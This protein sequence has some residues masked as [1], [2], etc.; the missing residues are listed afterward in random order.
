MSEQLIDLERRGDVWVLHLC[1]EDNRFNRA[2][3]D[4]LHRALDQVESTSGPA[5][6]VTTGAGKFYSNGL[7]LDWLLGGGPDTE[8]FLPDV[9]RLLGRVLGLDVVTVAAINGHAFA[10]GAMLASAHDYRIMRE[11]RGYWCLPEVDLGLPLTP[12]MYAVVAAHLPRPA[13]REAA[14]TGMRYDGPAAVAAGIVDEVAAEADVVERA[15][16]LATGLAGKNREVIAEHK[17][18]MYGEAL[19]LCGTPREPLPP[20][21]RPASAGTTT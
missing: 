12:A 19:A 11:D 13:V 16:A 18:L 15:V 9:H 3:V 7:D 2:S 1:H 4:G 17:R 21:A 20:P 10:G 6:L 8:G 14:L 5:A